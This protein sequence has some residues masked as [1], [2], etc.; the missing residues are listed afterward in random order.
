MKNTYISLILVLILH[1]ARFL[2]IQANDHQN[3]PPSEVN[4]I[5]IERMDSLACLWYMKQAVCFRTPTNT[6]QINDSV[7]AQFPDSVYISR[8]R[9]LDLTMNIT[10]NKIVRN[11]IHVYTE[12]KLDKFQIMLGL[13]DYYLPLF[14]EILDANQMPLELKYLPVV[15]SALNPNAVSRAGATGLWQFMY[16]T[17][18][19]Y[20]L[21]INSVIDERRDPLLASYA[22]VEYLKDLYNIYHDWVLV[23]AA[24]NC[25]PGNVNKAIRRSGGRTNYWDIYYYLPRET[26]GYVPAFIAVTYA[27]NFYKE[28]NISPVPVEMPK[29]TDTIHIHKPLHLDQVAQVMN[30]PLKMLKQINPQYRRDIIPGGAKS[31]PLR[32]PTQH[33]G[34]FIELADSIYNYNDSVYF[35][36]FALREPTTYSRSYQRHTPPPGNYTKVYY[37]VKSGDNLG[38]IA[39][40]YDVTASKI[41][42]WNNIRGNLI[43]Q[44]EKL[45]IY[46]PVNKSDHYKK[47]NTMSFARKQRLT[48]QP[49]KTNPTKTIEREDGYVYYK[50]QQGDTIWDIAKKFPG[51]S[52]TDI[53]KIN[54]IDNGKNLKPGQLIKIKKKG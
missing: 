26:R 7:I 4:K 16:G 48:G 19:L 17:G 37:T 53:L 15:E 44:G 22:G 35:T 14:E 30:I 31:W 27:M 18:K 10:Y 41:R 39:E 42:Y 28:H 50:V 1:S 2:Y 24:Y 9:S 20:D 8:L 36:D 5:L 11:F 34:Q 13:Q 33:I 25:G 52:N 38:F 29:I 49:V 45:L 47:I 54:N 6:M 46:V 32:L 12:K 3:T 51:V 40:W 21:T 43:R 23:I